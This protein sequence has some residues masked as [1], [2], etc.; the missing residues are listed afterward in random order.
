MTQHKIFTRDFWLLFVANFVVVA[1]YFLLMT[2]MAAFVLG[3]YS[4][5]TRIC[6]ACISRR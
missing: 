6:S 2:T 5:G 1:V 3:A 4:G